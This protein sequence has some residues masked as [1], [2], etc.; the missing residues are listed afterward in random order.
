[1]MTLMTPGSSRN[2]H[3]SQM[4]YFGAGA[5]M[6]RS[7]VKEKNVNSLEEMIALA[8][9]LVVRMI[10]CEMSRGLMGIKESELM[11]GLECGGV[12]S[13]L[14]DSFIECGADAGPMH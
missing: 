14:S 2:L 11:P 13:F 7:M 1:M 10:A 12:A 9:E 5:K 8:R 6:L 3:V 4:N